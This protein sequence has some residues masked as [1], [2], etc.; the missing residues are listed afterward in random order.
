MVVGGIN[1]V[2]EALGA[3]RLLEVCVSR[4]GGARARELARRAEE[5]GVTVRWLEPAAL[6]AMTRGGAH[7]GIVAR[8]SAPHGFSIAELVDGAKDVPLLLVLDGIEDPQNLGAILRTADAAGVDGIVRQTRHAAPLSASVAKASAG[9]LAHVRVAPVVNISQALGEL[10]S[11]GVWT[12]G[13]AG[14]VPRRYHEVDLSLPTA[15]VLGAEDRGLRRLVRER[16]DWL[17][18]I[19]MHGRVGSLNVAVAAGVALY[20]VLRQRRKERANGSKGRA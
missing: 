19:P 6:D 17:V 8:V 16:C 15:L 20:E 13:L 7:Q 3:G 14:K 11:L 2:A 12:V 5:R 9:A 18:S 1:P 10:K 4:R